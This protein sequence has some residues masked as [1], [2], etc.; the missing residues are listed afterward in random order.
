ML[1]LI[2]HIVRTSNQR[3]HTNLSVSIADAIITL[4]QP[5]SLTV[6]RVFDNGDKA[7]IYACAGSTGE[8]RF[9]RNAYLP[10]TQYSFLIDTDP[11]LHH[12]NKLRLPFVEKNDKDGY[13][14]AFL[15]MPLDQLLYI[16]DIRF[17][18]P[19]SVEKQSVLKGFIEYFTNHV[20]LLDYGET[21][22]LT[23]LP[24]RKTFD[25]HLYEV[26]SQAAI[27]ENT[28]LATPD[29]PL[30]RKPKPESHHWLAVM[31]I[32]HFKSVNDTFG[33]LIGDEVLVMFARLIR[34]TFRF[35]DQIFRFG[36]EEFVVVTQPT[37]AESIQ[38]VFHRFRQKVEDHLFSQVGK[39]TVSI[40]YSRL[41]TADTPPN[42]IDRAD[43]ALYYV[44][45]HGRNNIA[46]H[47]TLVSSGELT[48]KQHQS[49][50]IE[51]F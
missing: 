35:Q 45:Q 51:L 14:S 29:S 40:G 49:D 6:Y 19:P 44:K 10:D 34:E 1:Q 47:E 12:A 16:V 15:V 37:D 25:K 39:V 30:R 50:D 3:D 17:A 46:C 5:Q 48:S 18:Q 22:A 7:M 2:D 32:D 41:T 24:N 33:H 20:G 36:G 21:D 31:D 27:D 38:K 43:E 26:L 13:R 8:S 23:R 11:L 42:V 4:F 9:S 28:S